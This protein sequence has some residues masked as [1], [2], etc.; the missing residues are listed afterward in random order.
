MKTIKILL[1]ICL[2]TVL[3]LSNAFAVLK[4]SNRSIVELK[5]EYLHQPLGVDMDTPR[6]CWQM[7][8]PEKEAYQIA[9]QILV[10]DNKEYL[11]SC[12]ANCWDSGK[13]YSDKM[14]VYYSGKAL[15]PNKSY[16][17][18]VIIWD[19]KNKDG[20]NS[21]ISTFH[22]GIKSNWSA[23]WITDK[24]D[25]NEK[26]ASHF[27]KK[28][29]LKANISKAIIYIASAGL[30]ELAINDKKV[31]DEFLNPAF[32][33]FDKRI[34]YNTYE[35]TNLL[36][37]ESVIDVVLGNGWYNLQS[38]AVWD[39]HKAPWRARP[40]F[41]FEM[42]IDYKDGSFESI[43]SDKTWMSSFDK[44]QFNSIYTAEHI[45]NNK[46]ADEWKKV[47]EV[48]SPTKL[49]CSQQMPPIRLIHKLKAVSFQKI[50]SK[51]YLYDFGQNLS[52]IT[53]LKISG[54]RELTLQVKYGEQLKNGRINNSGLEVHYR[55]FDNTDPFQ[56]DIY[57]LSGKQNELFSPKFNYKGF[58]YVEVTAVH[59]F[60][61]D[62]S[63]LMA[64]FAHSDV[65][66]VG[67]ISSSNELINKIWKATNNSYLSNLF[68]YPTDC[69]QREKN[70]WTGDGHIAI[71]TG[72]FNF[73]GI[74]IYEKW[75]DDHRDEQQTD[76]TLPAIIP[77]A[78]WGYTWANGVDWTSSM[79]LV[80][81]NVYL[82]YGDSHILK[83]NY[84]NMKLYLNKI[85]S[86][87]NNNLTDWGLGDWVP[88]KSK[89][90][91]E[92]TSSNFYYADALILSKI[93]TILGFNSDAIVFKRLADDIKSSINHKYFNAEK[94]I[95]AQGT[96]TELSMAL[97]N[98]IVPE[99]KT[100]LVANKLVES[101]KNNNM[102][103]DIGL[104]GSKTIL[105]ALSQNGY[106][107]MAFKLA[108]SVDYPSWGY[109][110]D[111]G[112]T[113]L[114]ENWDLSAE[115]DLSLNHIM[116]GEI[117]AWYYKTLGGINI[118]E[119]KPGFKNIILKPH[120]VKGLNDINVSHK[121]PNGDIVSAW[122]RKM[123]AVNYT[124]VIPPNSNAELTFPSNVK[125]IIQFTK[126][127]YNTA[128]S[129]IKLH[130]GKYEFKIII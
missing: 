64:Y 18:K 35:V 42:H 61:I 27:R 48:K 101:I 30:H 21:E 66:P 121:C 43:I 19:N 81:W 45:D 123:N 98:G 106:A 72:L 103:L 53:E 40:R 26:R 127:S 1:L 111:N 49:I 6:L 93:A 2:E 76:G 112:A 38:H 104:L 46:L 9:Y 60:E 128:K 29:N 130:A 78:G 68:G 108:S 113:T 22:T 84:A 91:V 100:Q 5:C 10:A 23:T 33:R 44:I 122:K 119:N 125:D 89:S 87:A 71:E 94:N 69:P 55:P 52:G 28:I 17:W 50:D 74:K 32:T 39:F 20:L 47:I 14:L 25:V 115:S 54:K 85:S 56:T 92:F 77:T 59:D 57:T 73:D 90:N 13:V 12:K 99:E 83:E 105:N 58:R 102:K 118:D 110:M 31:G 80:P 70:G 88:I 114:Y 34:L 86:V 126:D 11:S 36:Q 116:F 15:Q 16:F 117:S 51:T 97:Y 120:F 63:S 4:T 79:I 41:I 62:K 95:Y 8:T 129:P 75:M 24:E 109:W 67:K 3:L 82:F 65:E 107:D 96:Q 37:T 124:I 7:N